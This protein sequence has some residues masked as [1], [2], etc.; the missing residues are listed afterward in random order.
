MYFSTKMLMSLCVSL[1]H[2]AKIIID[3]AAITKE[4]LFLSWLLW[5]IYVLS[6]IQGISSSME[7]HKL[8]IFSTLD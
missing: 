3:C 1:D 8:S 2:L 4:V 5:V 7:F 6:F